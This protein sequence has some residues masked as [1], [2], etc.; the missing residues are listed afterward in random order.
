MSD[1]EFYNF[2]G[3][4]IWYTRGKQ[5][6]TIGEYGDYGIEYHYADVTKLEEMVGELQS[7]IERI[8][9]DVGS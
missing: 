5:D 3:L 4:L 8:K 1:E 9:T 2:Y 6:I 7:L